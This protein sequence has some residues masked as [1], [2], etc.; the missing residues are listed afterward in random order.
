MPKI[1]S[2]PLLSKPLE[3]NS[4]VLATPP[5]DNQPLAHHFTHLRTFRNPD[6]E[7]GLLK[8]PLRTCLK[9]NNAAVFLVKTEPKW[10]TDLLHTKVD[11]ETGEIVGTEVYPTTDLKKANKRKIKAVDRFCDRFQPLYRRKVVSLMFATLTLANESEST[12][13]DVIA[14]FKK[15]CK[16]AGI[17]LQG[18]L[19]ISEV[20]PN[21]HWH[22]HLLFAIDRINV[23][24]GK[25]PK[26]LM[27]DDLWGPRCQIEFVKKDV[28][29]YLSK[30]FKKNSYRIEGK[31]SYGM[32]ISKRLGTVVKQ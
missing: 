7:K 4:T 12:I 23:S 15:R 10:M 18:Y 9:G 20:S 1:A 31:R 16:R 6:Y 27:L 28:R 21:L 17:N 25:I 3:S 29:F 24:G 5:I 14:N 19:W 22:Y 2:R 26:P 32:T 13:R 8:L 11:R 30:Y